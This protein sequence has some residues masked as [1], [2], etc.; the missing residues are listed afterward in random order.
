MTEEA[1]GVAAMPADDA[2]LRLA[3]LGSAPFSLPTLAA[4]LGAGHEV[5][6]VYTQPPRP[7]GRGYELTRSPVDVYADGRGLPVRTPASLRDADEQRRFAELDLD[8]AVVAAYG[9]ILPTP[10]LAA[11]RLGCLNVH[12]SLLPRWRGAAPIERAIL[13]G[14]D[15]TGVTIMQ[16]DAGLDTGPILLAGRVPIGSET[17]AAAL[18]D[19]LA[20]LGAGLMLRALAG[21]AAGTLRST[22]QPRGRRDLRQEARARRRSSRLVQAGRRTAAGGAR[23]EPSTGCL[24]RAGGR[25]DQ[26]VGRG[27]GRLPRDARASV[28]RSAHHCLRRRRAA[29]APPAASGPCADRDGGI[30]ARL[31]A[32]ARH[33]ARLKTPPRPPVEAPAGPRNPPPPGRSFAVIGCRR[34]P[35]DDRT[36]SGR[37]R[38]RR[39][40][41]DHGRGRRLPRSGPARS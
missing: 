11:P 13:A 22:P 19:A 14:D 6:A 17:T 23:A 29:P 21:L 35:A 39:S 4:L 41:V 24:V 7:A 18:H 27:G 36:P 20:D 38:T 30:S 3:F 1:D 37:P 26:G 15:E 12:A 25:A 34:R 31:S 16:V 33:P 10:I 5:T 28:G 32:A 8:A 9:L 2:R 40:R